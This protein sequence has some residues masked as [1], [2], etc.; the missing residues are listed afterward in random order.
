MPFV[1]S[2]D[3]NIHYETFGEGPPMVWLHGFTSCGK[4]WL[5]FLP[6]FQVRSVVVDA[7]GHGYSDPSREEA[8]PAE[9]MVED[10]VRVMEHAGVER[11]VVLGHSMGGVVAQELALRH[12]GRVLGLVLASTLPSIQAIG[13]RAKFLGSR[14]VLNRA[15]P[16]SLSRFVMRVA[17]PWLTREQAEETLDFL[18]RTDFTTLRAVGRGLRAFHATDRLGQIRCPALVIVGGRD[19]LTPVAGNEALH[20]AIPGSKF[21]VV[22]ESGHGMPIER[23]REFA[24]AVQEF[25]KTVTR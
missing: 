13:W 24:A 23:P 14:L 3:C 21:V 25:L 17:E 5:P 19:R 1:K 8:I 12:P 9:M 20:R 10:V 11:A 22:P 15:V 4:F 7:R 6:Q 18:T 16:R 2:G